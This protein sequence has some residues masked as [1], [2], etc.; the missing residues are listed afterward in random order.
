MNDQRPRYQSHSLSFLGATADADVDG[1]RV[2]V[3]TDGGDDDGDNE[4]ASNGA[5]T[6]DGTSMRSDSKSSQPPLVVGDGDDADDADAAAI[7]VTL[8]GDT[9]AADDTDVGDTDDTMVDTVD[10]VDDVAA[11][12]CDVSSEKNA[13]V[14][15]SADGALSPQLQSDDTAATILGFFDDEREDPDRLLPDRDD[16]D[17]RSDVRSLLR[18]LLLLNDDVGVFGVDADDG[19]VVGG[20]VEAVCVDFLTSVNAG[21][22]KPAKKSI[23]GSL[24]L[25]L[26]SAVEA[27]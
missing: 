8:L 7:F 26:I 10:M 16:D 13:S 15:I 22:S 9:A 24:L 27:A 19:L 2:D 11:F 18:S 1:T 17:E 25:L 6:A 20:A 12:V 23:S 3:A 21:D 4:M 5:S 14:L